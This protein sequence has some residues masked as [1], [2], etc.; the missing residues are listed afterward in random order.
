MTKSI[1]IFSR[2]T[3]VNHSLCNP[4]VA[5][6]ILMLIMSPS[7][8]GAGIYKWV[9]ENGKV[10]YGSQ[11]PEDAKAEKMKLHVPEPAAK[12]ES[13]EDDKEKADLSHEDKANQERKAYCETERKRLQTVAKNKEIHQKDANGKVVKMSSKERDERLNKIKANISKYCK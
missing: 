6:L 13:A 10:H 11:R 2:Y 9:D 3:S 4:L 1:E 7:A 8:M 5:T 12:P